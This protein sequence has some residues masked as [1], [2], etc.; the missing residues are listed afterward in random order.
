M[1][2]FLAPAAVISGLLLTVAIACAVDAA[3]VAVPATPAPP[4]APPP[5]A[6]PPGVASGAA[7]NIR[8]NVISPGVRY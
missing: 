6:P 8:V 3:E 7:V 5:T 2:K 1:Q 4:G